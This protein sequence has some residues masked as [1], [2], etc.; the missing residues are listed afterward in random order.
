MTKS[1]ICP[2]CRKTTLSRYN[3]DP[4]CAACLR[5]SRNPRIR[6]PTWLW[7]SE[8]MRRALAR[9][10]VGAV[11][12]ILRAATGLSQID[13]ANLMGDGWSQTTVSNVERRKRDTLY[14]IRE[15][16]RFADT[17]DMPREAL[18]P[19]V[20]GDLDVPLEADDDLC[21]TGVLDVNRRSFTTLTASL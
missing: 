7:D 9:P 10:D 19:L 3:S 4:V 15:L 8:P 5:A 11:V 20:P 6:V 13:F 18:P 16:R 21:P 12:A 17:V 14:D 2:S 1:L